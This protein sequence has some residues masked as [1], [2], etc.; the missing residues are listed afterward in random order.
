MGYLPNHSV[1]CVQIRSFFC[2]VFSRIRTKKNSVFGHFSRKKYENYIISVNFQ[3][4]FISLRY[5][6]GQFQM[7]YFQAIYCGKH[8]P[9]QFSKILL[10]ILRTRHYLLYFFF[11]FYTIIKTKNLWSEKEKLYVK[12]R[13]LRNN[14][15]TETNLDVVSTLK[16][17]G[18]STVKLRSLKTPKRYLNVHTHTKVVPMKKVKKLLNLDFDVESKLHLFRNT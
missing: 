12:H 3:S 11:F 9:N 16:R 1:K 17:R 4:R 8:L 6:H 15:Q 10:E 18:V 5:Y 13:P 7:T 14:K 2:S